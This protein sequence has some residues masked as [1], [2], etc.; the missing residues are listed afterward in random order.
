MNR[1]ARFVLFLLALALLPL[2]G[3]AA[4]QINAA[5]MAIAIESSGTPALTEADTDRQFAAS[6]R[7]RCLQRGAAPGVPC[8][9]D[10]S[11]PPLALEPAMLFAAGAFDPR[12]QSAMSSLP[13]DCILGPPRDC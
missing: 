2:G 5:R 7:K 6:L 10:L 12:P 3:I 9:I 11:P 4:P 13:R 8:N 1:L